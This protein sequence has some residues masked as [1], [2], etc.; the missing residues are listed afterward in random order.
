MNEPPK[1]PVKYI[2]TDVYLPYKYRAGDYKV[3]FLHA[4]KNKKFLGSKCEKTGKVFVPP[5]VNSSE[6]FAPAT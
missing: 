1:E 5:M 3:R 6:S 4:L 2:E